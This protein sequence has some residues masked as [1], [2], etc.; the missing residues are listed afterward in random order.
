MENKHKTQPSWE[1]G[2]HVNNNNEGKL[3]TTNKN[4]YDLRLRS[5]AISISRLTAHII[6]SCI[7]IYIYI[8]A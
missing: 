5:P 3:S 4:L 7:C 6:T 2:S 1:K 8:V